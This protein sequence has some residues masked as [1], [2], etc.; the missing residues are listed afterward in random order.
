MVRDFAA[1]VAAAAALD[2]P[3]AAEVAASNSLDDSVAHHH[4]FLL[5]YMRHAPPPPPAAQQVR[6]PKTARQARTCMSQGAWVNFDWKMDVVLNESAWLCEHNVSGNST[7]N[8][9]R[10]SFEIGRVVGCERMLQL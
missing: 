6:R 1:A 10:C 4:Y 5:A 7:S 3:S 2:S 8:V 9:S